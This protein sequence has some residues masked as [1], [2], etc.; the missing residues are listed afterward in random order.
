[1]EYFKITYLISG[2]YKTK[3]VGIILSWGNEIIKIRDQS[4]RIHHLK[5]KYVTNVRPAVIKKSKKHKEQQEKFE[6][7]EIDYFERRQKV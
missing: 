6:Q 1:M 5:E 2:K 3:Y 4:L 7:M